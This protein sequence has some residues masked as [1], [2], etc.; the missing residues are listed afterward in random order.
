MGTATPSGVAEF[1]GDVDMYARTT[2]IQADP[3]KMDDGL[4][5]VR[6]KI[7]PAVS[8]IDG[9]SGMSL[10][11]DRESGR[12]IATTSWDS[13]E[14]MLGSAEQVRPLR[15]EAEKAFG[16]NDASEVHQW[17]VAVLHR[18]HPAPD[19]ACARVTWLSGDEQTVERGI[20]KYKAQVLPRIQKM[21]GFCSASLLVDRGAGRVA[22]TAVF[23]TPEALEASRDAMSEIRGRVTGEIGATV[24][25]VEELEVAFAHLHV[26]ETV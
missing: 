20:E 9:C 22:G 23:E 3:A 19:T 8:E 10:L 13:E 2:E 24:I 16:T 18:H 15:D 12:G 7:F 4:R 1:Q 6:E 5:V 14:A 21:D 26:P 17:E 11:V 25:G